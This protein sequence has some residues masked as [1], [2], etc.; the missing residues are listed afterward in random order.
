[1][2]H[3]FLLFIEKYYFEILLAIL[4]ITFSSWLMFYTFSYSDGTFFT[5]G[6]AW[7][8]FASHIPLI[9]SFSFGDNFPPEYPLF[10]G[11]P[12][13]YHFLFYF[14][15]GNLER[16]GIPI[17]YA[18]NIPSALGFFALLAAIYIF[19]WRL[20][21]SRFV[22]VASVLFF[23]FNGSLSFL[24]YF[25]KNPLS[26]DSLKQIITNTTFPSFGP[27]DGQLVSAFWNLNIFTNQRHFAAAM[28]FSLFIVYF[29][30]NPVFQKHSHSYKFTFRN[31][32]L[33]MRNIFKHKFSTI[34]RH[35]YQAIH[36]DLRF[37]LITGLI[38][39]LSFYFHLAAFFMTSVVI[40]FLAFC[41]SSLR[42]RAI[43]LLLTA[44]LFAIPQ[45]LYLSHESA[46][47]SLIFEP[48][49]LAEKPLTFL[50]S[51]TYWYY[52]FG[53]HI[54][55][56]PL[57]FIF[58]N[59]RNKKIL[60]SFIPLF[61]IGNLFQ[62]SPEMAANHKFFNYFLIIGAMYSAFALFTL[63]KKSH[64]AK[65][66]VAVAV[67]FLV[68]SGII[69]LFPIVN[70]GKIPL[71]D[72]PKN[73]TVAWIMENTDPGAVFLNT[74]Y[75]FDPASLAG[76][77]I[78]L[79]WPYFAWSAGHDTT[80]RYE[81]MKAV[82]ENN[83]RGNLCTFLLDKKLNYVA[84]AEPSQDFQFDPGFLQQLPAPLFQNTDKKYTI[85]STEL[86]C[87]NTLL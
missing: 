78:Y 48:G 80:A 51:I 7:S 15:V 71:D 47:Y 36:P 2:K 76:R 58:A 59:T 75:L 52:N 83:N 9:R 63:W 82:I 55:L 20:F 70:D 29:F 39:G 24:L 86:I 45:Y 72:Y 38:L 49:Y 68:L 46:A 57:G 17:H 14:L 84:Y 21:R 66:V 27:Y 69:E 23:L 19:S 56:I 6:K 35:I 64:I 53:M 85:Y 32:I 44:A 25:Q 12:I 10:S 5:A 18:L 16:L 54:F 26:Q 30:L 8:D 50:S 81:E 42:I 4:A 62:F 13:H 60:L 37:S 43:I 1:M 79:G 41:F 87:G 3:K 73:Q 31:L 77:K 28:A 65:P 40:V 74:T 22:S 11:P 67:F 33:L 61:I 34:F